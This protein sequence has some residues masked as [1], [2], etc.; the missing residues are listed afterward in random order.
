MYPKFRGKG[1]LRLPVKQLK[2]GQCD[3]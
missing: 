1:V 3:N 2:L